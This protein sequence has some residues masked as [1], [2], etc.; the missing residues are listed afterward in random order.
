MEDIKK[1]LHQDLLG[2]KPTKLCTCSENVLRESK[3][4]KS[5]AA[6]TTLV[7]GR[8]QVKMPWKEGGPPKGSNY[9]IALKRMFSSEK[10]F[11]KKGCFEVV[12]QEVQKLLE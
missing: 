1:L 9:D 5:L 7:E 11:Q 4:M 6:S 12:D 3:F 10:S 8:I 2:V